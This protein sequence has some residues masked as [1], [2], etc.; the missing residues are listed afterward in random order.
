MSLLRWK[1]KENIYPCL[2]NFSFSYDNH[3]RHH[4]FLQIT[5][6][7]SQEYKLCVCEPRKG[8]KIALTI[9]A[10]M[11]RQ[12]ISLF[13]TPFLVSARKSKKLFMFLRRAKI[14]IF[15]EYYILSFTFILVWWCLPQGAVSVAPWRFPWSIMVRMMV[16]G[17]SCH[18]VIFIIIN[19]E[20][21]PFPMPA[22]TLIIISSSSINSL[23]KNFFVH[24]WACRW[25]AH[26]YL[27][28]QVVVVKRRGMVMKM[29]R[30]Q[31]LSWSS[32]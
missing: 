22:T 28:W 12:K 27:S 1:F 8:G 15:Y 23:E 2:R 19:I 14:L 3:S 17:V 21:L 26:T 32:S 9:K 29:W 16:G 31:T 20:T 10:N 5:L 4:Y 7:S 6:Q 11:T 13:A 18:H 24:V 25:S 30:R